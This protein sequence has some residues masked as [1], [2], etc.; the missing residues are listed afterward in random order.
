MDSSFAEYIMADT[1]KSEDSVKY[2]KQENDGTTDTNDANT[3]SAQVSLL[4]SELK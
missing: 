4:Q 1:C 3:S 2:E